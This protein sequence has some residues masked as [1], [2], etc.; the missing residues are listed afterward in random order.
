[1]DS[2]GVEEPG[3]YTIATLKASHLTPPWD[4]FSI[5]VCDHLELPCI[6][7]S[8]QCQE[9]WHRTITRT[10]KG[11]M[12]GATDYVLDEM[13]PTLLFR[14]SEVP[15]Q[16]TLRPEGHI[17]PWMVRKALDYIGEGAKMMTI[18]DDVIYVLRFKS[19]YKKIT[20][21]AINNYKAVFSGALPDKDKD[22]K[23]A[24]S[25]KVH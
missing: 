17:S 22:Y 16:L 12:R 21:Q 18:K 5:G 11:H 23:K 14:D 25:Q 4:T 10:F 19:K 7:P 3:K 1:M 2:D 24:S 20:K 8:Q 13:L 9:A 15:L 6:L